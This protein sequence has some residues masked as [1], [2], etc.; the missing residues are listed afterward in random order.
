MEP[1]E[2]IPNNEKHRKRL[3]WILHLGQK[4]WIQAEGQSDLC[5][6]VEIGFEDMFVKDQ[7]GFEDLEGVFVGN[8]A[9]DFVVELLVGEGLDGLKALIRESGPTQITVRDT[10]E[11]GTYTYI[12]SVAWSDAG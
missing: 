6:L 10:Q 1:S 8:R 5:R 7:E 12:S 3:L 4:P 9:A 11:N 2:L